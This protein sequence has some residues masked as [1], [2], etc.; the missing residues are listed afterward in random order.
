MNT[1]IT[2]AVVMAVIT[3]NTPIGAMAMRNFDPMITITI[4]IAIDTKLPAEQQALVGRVTGERALVGAPTGTYGIGVLCYP[5]I[6]M[7]DASG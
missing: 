4:G 3:G 5:A 6:E 2:V 1:T 7:V